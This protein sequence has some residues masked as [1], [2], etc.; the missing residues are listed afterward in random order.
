MYTTVHVTNEKRKFIDVTVTTQKEWQD[1]YILVK[2]KYNK[3]IIA[4]QTKL[5]WKQQQWFEWQ[6]SVSLW[7][8]SHTNKTRSCS[9]L[10]S[11]DPGL[12]YDKKPTSSK[13]IM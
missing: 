10:Q 5:D 6:Q 8:S 2:Y 9:E 13:K 3:K 1:Y 7:V 4:W 11:L 12:E